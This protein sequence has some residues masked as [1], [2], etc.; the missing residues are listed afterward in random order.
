MQGVR[1][2][3][4]RICPGGGLLLIGITVTSRPAQ[5]SIEAEKLL[6]GIL[7]LYEEDYPA[8]QRS[9]GGWAT[10]QQRLRA[11]LDDVLDGDTSAQHYRAVTAPKGKRLLNGMIASPQVYQRFDDY[12]E[13][14]AR[15][16]KA[17]DAAYGS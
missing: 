7:A 11:Y 3:F 15:I 12:A 13:R 14:A 10:R 2:P 17:I 5:A 4:P 8:I 6:N 9:Q 16:I 1:Y